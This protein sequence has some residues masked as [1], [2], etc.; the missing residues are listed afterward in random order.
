MRPA[1]PWS[2]KGIEPEAREAA[3]QAARRAGLTLGAWL[4][5]MIMD[6]GTDD[7]GQ[8]PPSVRDF[9]GPG[10]DFGGFEAAASQPQSPSQQGY[11]GGARYAMPAQLDLSPVTEAVRDLVRRIDT[12]ERR[13]ETSLEALAERVETSEQK[14][15]SGGTTNAD[16]DSVLERK[17]QQLTDRLEAAERNR[18]PFG[19]R[20]ED[21]IAFQGLEKTMNAVV[22]HMETVD[23]QSEQKFHEIRQILSELSERVETSEIASKR[24]QERARADAFGNTLQNLSERMAEMEQSVH[25]ATTN[26]EQN[27]RLAVD[28][29]LKA[30]TS[31][32]DSDQQ[33]SRMEDM[34]KMVETLSSRI[35]TSEAQSGQA[36][37][38]LEN[39]LSSFIDRL[40]KRQVTAQDIVPQVMSQLDDRFEQVLA[41]VTDSETRAL[42]TASSVEQA[43]SALAQSLH[44]AEER[45]AS[46]RETMHGL[47]AQVSHRIE[48]LESGNNLPLSPSAAIGAGRAG[49]TPPPISSAPLPPPGP[50]DSLSQM[51]RSPEPVAPSKPAEKASLPVPP[52]TAPPLAAPS[53]TDTPPPPPAMSAPPMP[54]AQSGVAADADA[55][56]PPIAQPA[57]PMMDDKRSARDFIAAARRAAQMAHATGEAPGLGFGEQAGRFAA[58]EEQEEG[59]GKRIALIVGGAVVALIVVLA[60]VNWLTAPAEPDLVDVTVGGEPAIDPVS[61]LDVAPQVIPS[62]DIVPT[63][64]PSVPTPAIEAGTAETLI[65]EAIPEDAGATVAAV[66]P[67]PAPVPARSAPIPE[68]AIAAPVVTPREIVPNADDLPP[69]EAAPTTP[70]TQAPAPGSRSAL[71]TAAAGGNAAAQYEVGVRYARGGGV[72]QDLDQAAYWFELAAKQDLAIAQYRLATLYEKGRGVPLNMEL[73]RQWYEKAAQAGNVKAMHNLA[74]IYA[75]GKGVQQ[76]FAQAGK[77]FLGA[78][79]HGLADSQ[80][81]IA[82]LM[83]R[84]LGLTA[85]QSEAYK[86]FSI[87]ANNGDEGAKARRDAL[88]QTLDAATLVDAKLAAQTWAPETADPLANGNLSSLGSWSSSSLD[89]GSGEFTGSIAVESDPQIASAQRLLRELGYQPGPA[90][91]MMGP[92]TRDAI[93]DFQTNAGLA[94]TGTANDTLIQTLEAYVR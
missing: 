36:I 58:F 18:S 85:D 86:W 71:R 38:T 14:I 6:Q 87:A 51:F 43:L 63:P 30:V 13:I 65:P 32:L 83:E 9:G 29:A 59:R 11:S 54:Q 57:A 53:R 56:E 49:M 37:K 3:K 55:G 1:V 45:N 48:D 76:D 68:P 60:A 5:Q 88:E 35:E 8:M 26:A 47:V 67:V 89:N 61:E 15:A 75:E 66:A 21:R 40:E 78:A 2:V 94:V 44:A 90:D 91:G 46:A 62:E 73:A 28:E 33:R 31:K 25:S 92:R 16:K 64:D 82:V 72:P 93:R 70:V 74:V 17:V 7:V 69:V 42:Q 22:D 10:R 24:D 39:S 27:R 20:P 84:G 52:M 19:K 12:N 81:N 50:L 23:N 41:R 77:W 34:Q 4:N 79:N 80:Y